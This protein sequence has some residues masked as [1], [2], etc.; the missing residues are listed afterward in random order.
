MATTFATNHIRQIGVGLAK[1]LQHR[2]SRNKS[3]RKKLLRHFQ[4]LLLFA[5]GTAIGAVACHLLQGRAIWLTLIP[6]AV[7][8]TA[9]LY[10][11]LKTE[12]S[13]L[14]RKPSGH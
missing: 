4:M 3:H 5:A 6:F 10:A 7:I 13:F 8:L 14:E 12:R 9:L 1:E 11:D 2:H